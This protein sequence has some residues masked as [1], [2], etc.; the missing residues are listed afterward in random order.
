[1]GEGGVDALLKP[2]GLC[3][4]EAENGALVVGCLAFHHGQDLFLA[5]GRH[6]CFPNV[7][8]WVMGIPESI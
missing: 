2:I 3:R 4:H 1:V 6:P 7:P 5:G 8:G